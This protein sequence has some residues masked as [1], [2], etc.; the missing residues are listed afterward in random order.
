M[1]FSV[2]TPRLA[3]SR[4][5]VAVLALAGALPAVAQTLDVSP[6]AADAA[7]AHVRTASALGASGEFV[8]TGGHTS[9]ASGATYVYVQQRVGGIDVDRAVVAVARDRQGRVAHVAGDVVAGAPAE[10]AA[11]SLSAAAAAERAAAH[12]GVSAAPGVRTSEATASRAT[13]LDPVAAAGDPTTARLVY[14]TPTGFPDGGALRLAW[15]VEVDVPAAIARWRVLVDAQTGEVLHVANLILSCTFGESPFEHAAHPAAGVPAGRPLVLAPYTADVAAAAP[16]DPLAGLHAALGAFVGSYKV[17][18]APVETPNHTSPLPPADGRTVVADPSNA[19]ASPYGWH[20]TDGV[21]GAEFTITRGNNAWANIDRDVTEG[22]DPTGAPDGGASLVFAPALDLSQDPTAGTNSQAATVNLFYW[23][24]VFHDILYQYGFTEAA[25]NFQTNNYGRGGTAGDAVL[26]EAQDNAGFNNANFSSGSR[27][28]IAGRMQMYLWTPTT[29]DRDGSF[30]NDIIAHEYGHGVSRRLIGTGACLGGNEQMG[31][32]WSDFYALM[33]TQ[34]VGD[35]R[36]RRRGIGTY[37]LGQ[38]TTGDGV[39]GTAGGQPAGVGA[40]YSTDF[41]VNG[42]TYGS[43]VTAGQAG[44]LTVPHGVGF[45]WMTVLW[46]VTWDMIDAHGFSPNLYASTGTAGNQIMMRLVTEA[47]KTTPCTPGF[48]DG[49]NAIL[50]ADALLYPDAAN[51]GYGIHYATLWGGFARRGLGASASQGSP[52][53]NADNVQAFDVPLAAGQAQVASAPISRLTA[54]GGTASATV[55]V[56]NAGP[57]GNVV[58]S[59]ALQNVTFVPGARP[60]PAAPPVASG[61]IAVH[62]AKAAGRAAG[63]P[64]AGGYIFDDSSE[65]GGPVYAFTDISTTGAAVS[66]VLYGCTAGNAND[67]GR[68]A[69][70]LPTPFTFYGVSYS[71]VYIYTNGLIGFDPAFTGCAYINEAIPTAAAPNGLIAPF[72]DDLDLTSGSIRTQTVGGNFVIQ[73]TNVPRLQA[74]TG[75]VSFQVILKPLGEIV[76]QY[77]AAPTT[78]TSATIGIE[79][80]AGTVGLQATFDAAYAAPRLAVR[81]RKR[82]TWVTASNTSGTVAP[83]ASAQI[84]LAFDATGLTEGTY[85]ADLVVTTNAWSGATTT[86]PVALTVGGRG[87]VSGG[88]GWRLLAAPATG[89]TVASLAAVNLVQGIPGYY[90]TGGANLLT[91]YTGTAYTTP[92]SGSTVLAPGKGFWWYF[93]NI[94]G[95]PGGPSTS[96][97]LPTTLATTNAAITTDTPV[98]LHAAGTKYNLMGNPFGVSLNLSGMASWTGAS[99]LA[100]S[101]AQVWNAASSSYETSVTRPTIAPWQGFW[102]QSATVGTFTIPAAARTTG[103]I[104]QRDAPAPTLAFDLAQ[105]DPGSEAG[106]GSALHDLAAVVTFPEGATE[107]QDTFDAG[108]LAPFA[109][110]FVTAALGADGS[111][112]VESLPAPTTG[113]VSVP[114]HVASVGAGTRLV[115]SWPL[116]EAV[117]D[118]WALT[119]TDTQTGTTV[120]LRTATEYAFIVQE[121]PARD[122]LAMPAAAAAPLASTPARFVVTVGPRGA[123][124]GEGGAASVFA[125]DA[126]APNPAR[127]A[128]A[129]AYSLAEAGAARVSVVDLLGREVAVVADGEQ[130]AGRHTAT[131]DGARLAPGVYVVRLSSGGEALSRRIVVVR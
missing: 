37:V 100:S 73:F 99:N 94:E 82:R 4:L 22:P 61:E 65:P 62:G 109:G 29:P 70:A 41:A 59:S 113:A 16:A 89:V 121:A 53:T 17:Y 98:A 12:V 72:W 84:G 69:V 126:P 96:H 105:A 27:D 95:T 124:A 115:L 35:T 108:K 63:G 55:Q 66:P 67:E 68:A 24:N 14:S 101:V 49:R 44:G 85:T 118:G 83:N 30:S 93:Y 15:A 79:N 20:D 88:P 119:L 71:T 18:G 86:I 64:D 129:L 74:G 45:A 114:L 77:Q 104:L 91:G 102:V 9:S 8:A 57:T 103:G 112:A 76:F 116:V 3:A 123:T 42:V 58:Y 110:T 111:R 40:P 50:A 7:V 97:A 127:G 13:T 80:Q 39:R 47:L 11:P 36:T 117:P 6:A 56:S 75:S 32:G 87:T 90:P 2:R 28:G 33:L 34:R 5:A 54:P 10:A 46:D 122:S 43:T 120:D 131:L 48:V 31:E 78:N 38:P 23:T 130:T 81:F 1:L 21:A 51:P 52:T 60:A 25:R 26:A 19:L 128:V 107:G 106:A 92:A 125:L